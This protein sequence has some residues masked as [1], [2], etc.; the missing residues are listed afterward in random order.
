MPTLVPVIITADE[1]TLGE[2]KHDLYG[3]LFSGSSTQHM[4]LFQSTLDCAFSMAPAEH[5]IIVSPFSYGSIIHEQIAHFPDSLKK[6]IILDGSSH[7]ASSLITA[8]AL[9]ALARFNDPVLWILPVH[10]TN[11]YKEIIKH[12]IR[13]S[14]QASLEDRMILYGMPAFTPDTRYAYIYN[15]TAD[16]HYHQLHHIRM[17][18]PH[19]SEKS[20]HS[21]WN[22]PGCLASSGMM[23]VKADYWLQHFSHDVLE[24]IYNAYRHK[25]RSYYGMILNPFLM[26]Q[27]SKQSLSKFL[28]L[29]AQRKEHKLY[30]CLLP[31]DT[32]KQNG[33]YQLWQQSQHTRLGIPLQRFLRQMI[34]AA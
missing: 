28:G 27:L 18:I 24:L 14:A 13:Y 17:F 15:G 8:A 23:L 20:I 16:P 30:S 25:K 22:Q 32:S 2:V 33:W 31:S 3:G 7:K 21:I 34:H 29:L 5:I 10:Q 9:H 19:P 1:H 6:N 11:Y 4:S 12:A 26:N